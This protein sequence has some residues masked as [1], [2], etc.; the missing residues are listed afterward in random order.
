MKWDDSFDARPSKNVRGEDV[1]DIFRKDTE[2]MIYADIPVDS[3][4]EIK[5]QMS[6][7]C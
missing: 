4:N 7:I 5:K 3:L 6:R 1:F 2:E